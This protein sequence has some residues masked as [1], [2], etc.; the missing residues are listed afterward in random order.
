VNLLITT[1]LICNVGG[2][3]TSRQAQPVVNKFLRRMEKVGG[4]SAKSLAGVYRTRLKDCDRYFADKKP[5]MIVTDLATYLERQ[6]AW[7]LAP[8]AHMGSAKATRYHLLV[9]EGTAKS[10]A[11]LEG[12][13]LVTTLARRPL[14]LS[15]IVFGGKLDAST[16]F[17]L[18]RTR[19][20][21]K[22]LRKVARGRAQ[23]TVVEALAYK[24]LGELKLPKKLVSIHASERLPGLTLSVVNNDKKL[25]KRI[26]ST[27][28]KLCTGPGKELC[29]TF[30]IKSFGRANKALYRKLAKRYK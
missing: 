3:G 24:Y 16:Y 22:G 17:K 29:K 11:E 8:L 14:F 18:K 23:A 1:L 21:L 10:V 20:P 30:R 28:S 25:G 19:R 2:P 27:L 5:K 6:Q 15:K 9:P 12:K 7:K 26:L 13:V 4:W